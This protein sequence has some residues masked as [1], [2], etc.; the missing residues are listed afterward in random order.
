MNVFDIG[1]EV[2]ISDAVQFRDELNPDVW[3]NEQMK[4]V[5]RE[6]L[7]AIAETFKEFLGVENLDVQDITLSGSNA[8]YTYTPHSDIDLHLLIDVPN[9]DYSEVYR[10]LFDAKKFQFNE[11]RTLRIKGYDVELYVQDPNQPHISAGIFSVLNNKWLSVPKKEKANIDDMSVISKVEAFMTRIDNVIKT[12]NLLAAEDVWEDIKDM[13]KT[14]L[15]RE[16]EF[17]PENISFKLLRNNG[18]GGK[19]RDHI[20]HLR[21]K[22]LSLEQKSL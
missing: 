3:E 6:R 2:K 9:V 21:D 18:Y 14:G 20:F 8:A 16:G 7:L 11:S 4:P 13:R 12:D 1:E 19:I 5:V 15:H 10:Q 22:D 17:S